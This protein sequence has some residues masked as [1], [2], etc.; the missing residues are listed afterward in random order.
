LVFVRQTWPKGTSV[1]DRLKR[2]GQVSRNEV[3]KTRRRRTQPPGPSRYSALADATGVNA[4]RI[5]T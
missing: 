4:T 5:M 1:G 3:K 2:C